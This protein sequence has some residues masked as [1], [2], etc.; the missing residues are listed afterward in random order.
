MSESSLVEIHRAL[1]RIEGR[2]ERLASLQSDLDELHERMDK[3]EQR[4][5]YLTGALAVCSAIG[6]WVVTHLKVDLSFPNVL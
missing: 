2:L 4:S 6:G 5:K 3:A 1:G